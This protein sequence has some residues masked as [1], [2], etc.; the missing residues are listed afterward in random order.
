MLAENR[1]VPVPPA[2]VS[3]AG[4]VGSG[5]LEKQATESAG[6]SKAFLPRVLPPPSSSDARVWVGAWPDF[7]FTSSEQVSSWC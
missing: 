5:S 1:R 3:G 2:I 7:V 4:A 6:G